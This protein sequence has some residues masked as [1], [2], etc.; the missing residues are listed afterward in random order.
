MSTDAPQE[1][2]KMLMTALV[3]GV[4]LFLFSWAYYIYRQTRVLPSAHSSVVDPEAI[5]QG[6][7]PVASTASI[8]IHE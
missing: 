7:S 4:L 5:G 1:I 2:S 8:S 6:L 3:G